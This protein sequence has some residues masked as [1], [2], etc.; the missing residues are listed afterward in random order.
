MVRHADHHH[1]GLLHANRVI[2]LSLLWAGLAA[3]VVGSVIY[4]AGHLFNAW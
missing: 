2:L 4:D 3:C 1:G